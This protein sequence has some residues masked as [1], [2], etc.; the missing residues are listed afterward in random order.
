[1]PT[2]HTESNFEDE[3]VGHLIKEGG[4]LQGDPKKYDRALGLYTEDVIGW[5]QDT[6]PAEYAKVKAAN[7]GSTDKVLIDRLVKSITEDGPLSVLRGEFKRLNTTFK[8]C[9]FKPGHGLNPKTLAMYEKVRCRVVRQVRYSEH[10]ENSIDV[11]LFVN[12]LPIVTLELKTDFTQ[13][14]EDAVTQY[15]ED[16]PPF[17][18]KTKKAEPLLT[19]K[20]G[21]LVHF[22]V[23]TDEVRMTTRLEGKNTYFLPFNLGYDDGSGNPPNPDGFRTAYL[24]ERVLQREALLEIL[25]KYLHLE[26]T[27]KEIAGKKTVSEQIIFPRYHQWD[28]VRKM[29][30]AAKTEGPG[31]NYLIQ[32]SAGSGKS[33]TI[34]WLAHQLSS[35]HNRKDKKVFDSVIIVTDRTVLDDQ[36]SD[37]V[38][39]F[40]HKD[41]VVIAINDR[42]DSKSSKLT[43]AL[44][45]KTP[46]I[47]VTIQTFPRAVKA[48]SE[49][50]ELAKRSFAVIA[51]EAHSSQTGE[52]AKAIKEG[53]GITDED[54]GEPGEIS[55]EDAIMALAKKRS[56]A[57]NISYFAFTATPKAKTLERF[58]RLNAQGIPESFH[59]Y[60]MQ[61]AIEEEFILDVLQNYTTYDV[62][63]KLA[64]RDEKTGDRVVPTSDAAKLIARAAKLHAYAIDQKVA[65]IVEHYR[66]HVQPLLGGRA[67][68]MVVCDSRKGAVRYKLAIDKY[69]K[70]KKYGISTLVAFSGKVEDDPNG[71]PDIFTENGMNLLK[72]EEI[73]EAFK[74]DRYQVLLVAEKYQT[75][76]NQPLLTAMY[77]D[78][79][80]SGITAVQTLS[81]LNRTYASG[82]VK[83][84]DTFILDFVNESEDILASFKPYYK[85]ATLTGVTDPDIIHDLQKKLDK[86][87]IYRL[88]ELDDY[89]A[90]FA[91][92]AALERGE[93]RQSLLMA[94]LNPIVDRYRAWAK[95]AADENDKA[96]IQNVVIF[97]DDVSAFVRLYGFLS[98]IYDYSDTGLEKRYLMFTGLA[99]LLKDNTDR[100]PVDV[101]GVDM[102][103][104]RASESF[105]GK[106]DL[107]KGEAVSL[108]P[109]T[110]VGTAKAHEKKYGVLAAVI[111][112]MNMV[113]GDDIS[114]EHKIRFAE[115]ARS[116]MIAD[117]TLKEQILNNS[118][119][120]V[121]N[122]GDT[123][124]FGERVLVEAQDIVVEDNQRQN[125]ALGEGLAK[126]LSDE[127]GLRNVI[128]ALFDS[129]YKY[130]H[131]QA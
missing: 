93:K 88:T 42:D 14:I 120:Q 43:K 34:M 27:K 129:A 25:E 122:S 31:E 36:L 69:I 50:P 91:K 94:V 60:T 75:G 114:D 77:V 46:I 5:I 13:S 107:K 19:F 40:D 55:A 85:T 41:G 101:S 1:M 39:Q 22:A 56:S 21:A 59:I 54:Q 3:L 121:M 104:F 8:M 68:A 10:N 110:G 63:H 96:E 81:R 131:G 35:L 74:S 113:F 99:R 98:Q 11:I 79:K 32:H 83:K 33:N 116:I 80:L 117:E 2:L 57:K 115:A 102:T 61:Q 119:Q 38:K 71:I 97:R 78:K 26:R 87:N 106:I 100:V 111:E 65:I 29:T 30:D 6:Q 105:S 47:I 109:T 130:H 70:E 72:N 103:H 86:S 23:S 20:R 64:T 90:A 127:D 53:L 16:R 112:A 15:K 95:K 49:M 92:A 12:G 124:D 4:W 128:S 66:E 58:G 37:A 108:L 9:A 123:K 125:T 45:Q 24:Y 28:A 76:F 73:P 82:E 67:K 62:A 44:K 18:K 52:S 17:D 84:T 89:L 126:L 48:L 51:D 7:N 118:F